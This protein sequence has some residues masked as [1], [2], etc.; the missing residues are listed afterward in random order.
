MNKYQPTAPNSSISAADVFWILL[1]RSWVIVLV[2]ACSVGMA[3]FVSVRTPKRYRAVAQLLLLQRA[4]VTVTSSQNSAGITPTVESVETQA[5]M[6]QSIAMGL[7]TLDWLK[8]DALAHKRSTDAIT[9]TAEELQRSITVGT[10]SGTNL[11]DVAVEAGSKEQALELVNAVC[12]TFIQ[13]KKEIAAQNAKEVVTGLETRVE[14]ARLAML[15]AERVEIAYRQ[16]HQLVDVGAQQKALLEQASERDNEV[17]KLQQ[18]VET[19]EAEVRTHAAHLKLDDQALRNSPRLRDDSQVPVLQGQLTEL[20]GKRKNLAA[21][22]MPTHPEIVALDREIKDVKDRLANAI[23]DV[24]AVG[25]PTLGQRDERFRQL[26][27]AQ[28][29]L[30]SSKA[31]LAAAVKARDAAKGQLSGIPRES[32]EHSRLERRV[33]LARGLYTQLQGTLNAVRLDQDMASGNVQISQYGYAPEDPVRPNRTRDL[34]FGIAAGIFLSLAAVLLL[35]QSDKRVRT[36]SN[37]RDIVPG[38]IVGMLPRMSRQDMEGLIG[39]VSTPRASEAY[40]LARANMA[41]ALR[42]AAQRDLWQQHVIMVTSAV[43]GEGKS[44]TAAAMA[45][46]IARTG[47]SVILVDADMRRPAQNGIF[48][49]DERIGLADVLAGEISL[50]EALVASDIDTL[51][52]LHSGTPRMSP[53]ELVSLPTMVAT[54]D[55]LREEA[56]VVIIDTPACAFMADALLIAPHADCV[57]Q[58]VGAGQVDED[59]VRETTTALKAAEPKMMLFFVNRAPKDRSNAYHSYYYAGIPAGVGAADVIDPTYR[60]LS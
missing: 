23:K 13:W 48:H 56:E 29:Q 38:P 17:T 19:R 22:F 39:G 47:R 59:L 42:S 21:R 36:V 15:E 9:I 10:Q 37:V 3:Y 49:T 43:P 28:T 14:R 18:E 53:T 55:K 4:P 8:N 45:C 7:R 12:Q 50:E 11:A 60:D 52:I 58:V 32:T 1:R 54:I 27:Q 31:Q 2:M 30:L 46:S 35:E 5:A 24:V 44:V 51:S 33:E 40:S 26:Q 57:L 6:L 41:L 34:G 16:K 25:N 20:E